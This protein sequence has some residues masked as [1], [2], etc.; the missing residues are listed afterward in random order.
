MDVNLILTL[1]AAMALPFSMEF[2][3]KQPQ[4]ELYPMTQ[5]MSILKRIK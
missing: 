4:T 1:R 2:G 3:H 5:K